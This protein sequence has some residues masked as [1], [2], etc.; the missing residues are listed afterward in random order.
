MIILI[1]KK[2]KEK[3]VEN[4]YPWLFKD[5]VKDII[6]SSNELKEPGIANLF[7]SDNRFIGKGLYIP[8]S[9]KIFKLLTFKDE[10]IDKSFFVR[11]ISRALELRQK[12]FPNPFY[13]LVNS[14][15][16]FIPGLIVDRYED[17]LVIQFRDTSIK[18]FESDIV[19]ALIEVLKPKG[20][21]ERSDF[22]HV[23]DLDFIQQNRTIFGE[24]PERLLIK[25]NGLKIFVNLKS[26]QKT[27][28]F[29][30]QRRN[31]L[32]SRKIAEK[33]KDKIGLDLYC[34]T[35]GFA[36]NMAL[37]GM[38]V[39]AVDKSTEDIELAKENA[40][41][42]DLTDRITFLNA[43]VEDFLE[44]SISESL[45]SNFIVFD[46]PSLIKSKTEK[47]KAFGIL[48]ELIGK[49]FNLIDEGCFSFSSC[50]Y[51]IDLDLMVEV[52][53]IQAGDQKKILR[54][55]NQTFQDVDH[56]WILQ[57]PE[58]LY[59]KTLWL[60]IEKGEFI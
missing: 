26:G 13:R 32:I 2:G 4:F 21:Q 56:P 41:L 9:R 33:F 12:E 8:N 49:S 27:G 50:A 47:R 55:I 6:G 17:S 18:L 44:S 7:S 5:E 36:L 35:G 37:S 57:I 51:N 10:K 22:E 31:R 46:P 40:K 23:E 43:R 15:A 29:Y 14:E 11:R 45:K 25:E 24:I 60:S 42:N 48:S 38:K 53:R 58:S 28:F 59:L 16:D 1:A 52:L 39:M 20:I 54:V 34:Y 30:D 19:E 3:K